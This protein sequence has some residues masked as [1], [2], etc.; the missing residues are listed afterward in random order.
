M[1][2]YIVP[3]KPLEYDNAPEWLEAYMRYRR[4]ILGSAPNTIMSYFKDL[5]E[6]LQWVSLTKTENI[7]VRSEDMLR[8]TD[9]TILPLSPV[10]EIRKSDI[11]NY[12]Y[13]CTDILGNSTATRSRKLTAIRSLYDYLYDQQEILGFELLGNPASRIKSPKISHSAPIYLPEDDQQ[14]LLESISGEN[15]ERDYAMILLFLVAGLRISELCSL[16]I[17]D[18]DFKAQTI[19]IRSGKGNKARVAYMTPACCNALRIYLEQYRAGISNLDTTALFVSKRFR[20]RITARAVEK[21][22]SKHI[23]RAELGGK[24]Y[25]PHKFR[26][27][28]AT[29]LAKEDDADLLRIQIVMGHSSPATTEIYTHLNNSDISRAVNKSSLSKLGFPPTSQSEE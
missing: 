20:K 26:H 28:T 17:S 22:V 27:T 14:Q 1:S 3:G 5:R 23:I 25:T 2:T 11:E 8:N 29:T 9:I 19:R 12:L 7:N 16:D 10:L 6:F 18:L 13:F 15:A 24:G 4:T 21:L